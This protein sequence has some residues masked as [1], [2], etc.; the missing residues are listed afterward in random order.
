MDICPHPMSFPFGEW[1]FCFVYCCCGCCLFRTIPAAYGSSQAR[2]ELEL[3]LPAY[4]TAT[5]TPDLTTSVSYTA[6]GNARSLN[7]LSE[8]KNQTHILMATSRAH[9]HW[10]TTGTPWECFW[11]KLTWTARYYLS[12]EAKVQAV[13][14]V[15]QIRC[16]CLVLLAVFPIPRNETLIG[17][18]FTTARVN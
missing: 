17:T 14:C 11:L 18:I 15:E 4:A 2:V 13:V 10:A 5:A 8:A 1:F 7:L 9:Y 12:L 6:H 16:S 3:Q